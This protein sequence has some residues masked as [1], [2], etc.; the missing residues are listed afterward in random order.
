[1]ADKTILLSNGLKMPA[2]MLGTF[3]TRGDFVKTAVTASLEEGYRGIDTA[4]VYREGRLIITYKYKIS[5]PS[6]DW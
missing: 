6:D 5:N 1:M 2:V 4:A 3:R